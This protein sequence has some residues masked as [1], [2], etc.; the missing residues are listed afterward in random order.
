MKIYD[1][2]VKEYPFKQL[3]SEILETEKIEKLHEIK[4]YEI[5]S[6][7]KDQSSDWHKKYYENFTKF[8]TLYIKFIKD[9]IKPIFNNNMIVY[10]KIPTFR[11]QLVGNLGVGQFHRDRDYNHGINEINFWLPFMDVYGNNSIWIESKEGKNDLHPVKLNY[12]QI[13]EFDGSNL[14]HGNKINDTNSTRVSVDFRVIEHKNF[15]PSNKGS[16]NMNSKFDIGGYFN[17]I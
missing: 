11:V 15:K 10:Q 7:E 2:D 12:G 3:I 9:F 13:L 8:D 14:L 17:I 4:N 5:F 16:I 6:R 1:Y